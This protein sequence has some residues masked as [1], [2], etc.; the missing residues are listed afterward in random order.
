MKQKIILKALFAVL[1]SFSCIHLNAETI[2]G[3]IYKLDA[4]TH[5]ASVDRNKSVNGN[6]VIPSEITF[7]DEVYRVTSIAPDAFESCEGLLSVTIGDNVATIGN[8]ALAYCSGLVSVTM[9]NGVTSIG[10]GAFSECTGL[11]SIV[12]SNSV[13]TIG[14]NAFGSSGL[15]SVTI[16]NS[17]TTIGKR[18]FSGTNLVSIS[19]PNSVASLGGVAFDGCAQLTS[20]TIGSGLTTLGDD[21]FLE[22]N[23]LKEIIVS[24]ENANFSSLNGILY[25]KLKTAFIYIP[26]GIEGEVNIPSTISSIDGYA[27][28]G[29]EKMTSISIPDNITDINM[30]TFTACTE[31]TTVVLGKGVS[32]IS[33]RAFEGCIKIREIRSLNPAP[34]VCVKGCF[35]ALIKKE[36]VLYVAHG[37]VSAYQEEIEWNTFQTFIELFEDGKKP[38]TAAVSKTGEGTVLID[39]QE[40]ET[41]TIK[42][43]SSL[44]FTITPAVGYMTDKAVLN[45]EDIKEAISG[46]Q[47]T[48]NPVNGNLE[49]EVAFKIIQCNINVVCNQAQGSVTINGESVSSV[50]I[51]ANNRVDFSVTPKEGY[52]IDKILVNGEE[53]SFEGTVYSIPSLI[54]DVTFEVR[55]KAYLIVSTQYD[56]SLGKVMIDDQE[57]TSLLVK[58]GSRTKITML[59]V[60]NYKVGQVTMNGAD[61]TSGIEDNAY[62]LTVNENAL[63]A[64]SFIPDG[65]SISD[66]SGL[67]IRVYS[68]CGKICIEG[69]ASTENVCI[70]D[71]TGKSVYCGVEREVSLPGGL[72]LVRM[73]TATFKV[74]VK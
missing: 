50:V 14:M 60:Q 71:V 34:P 41:A 63:L 55:F 10:D 48:V 53:K 69:V 37:S 31:L 40:V 28:A 66:L 36:C 6:I 47:Y 4:A 32:S 38:Y 62:T 22:C 59:P 2:D 8:Y 72:Y 3:L 23:L 15:T 35:S 65:N 46:N 18:A 25:N 67:G 9:G 19:I 11:T 16:G 29:C 12:I 1:F 57:V 33:M 49:L 26:K 24:E 42:E 27:F 74:I 39:G 54:G 43:G 7:N 17:V 30:G 73:D 51:P 21:A 20:V 70:T 44:P 52:Y 58:E 56:V 64:V 68:S 61:V 45:G 13:K 5:T